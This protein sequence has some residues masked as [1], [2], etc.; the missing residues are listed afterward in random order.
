MLFALFAAA[1]LLGCA[2]L[3]KAPG[4]D[5][6]PSWCKEGDA[7]S[8]EG[9]EL[10]VVDFVQYSGD[11]KGEFCHLTKD[12]DGIV[13]VDYYVDENAL[14]KI[15]GDSPQPGTGCVVMTPKDGEQSTEFC[16]GK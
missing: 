15:K 1:L 6:A 11:L 10:K 3:E 2:G 9:V 13:V 5:N 14:G 8:S 7:V 16:F 4:Q 12:Y